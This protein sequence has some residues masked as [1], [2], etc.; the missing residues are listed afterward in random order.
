LSRQLFIIILIISIFCKPGNSQDIHFSQYTDAPLLLNPALTG[1]ENGDWR[2]GL[3]YRKQWTKVSIP[4]NTV[5]FFIDKKVFIHSKIIML[6]GYV[7]VD[8]VS[9]NGLTKISIAPSIAYRFNYLKNTFHVGIQPGLGSYSLDKSLTY[10]DQFNYETGTFDNSMPTDDI[11]GKY[12]K[13][14]PDIALGV[15]WSRPV[16]G[17][18]PDIG[19]AFYHLNKPKTSIYSADSKLRTSVKTLVSLEVPVQI[20][21]FAEAIPSGLIVRQKKSQELILGANVEFNTS[22]LSERVDKL[23]AGIHYR[24]SKSKGMHSVIFLGGIEINNVELIA[25]YDEYYNSAKNLASLGSTFELS[26]IYKGINTFTDKFSLP[27]VVF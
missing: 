25:S 19:L 3:N 18:H 13:V 20:T 24:N 9:S 4:Y 21:R 12:S 7:L 14:F 6:G 23:I 27:C 5:N 2:A 10:P 1:P 15:S 16:Y 22:Q 11:P 8:Q 26:I 17:I